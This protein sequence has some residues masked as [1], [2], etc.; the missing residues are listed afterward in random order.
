MAW[1]VDNINLVTLP[2]GGH[3][4]G[5]NCNTTLF[6]LLHPV[7]SSTAGIA[8]DEVDFVLEASAVEN[9]LRC[10]GFTS[11]DMGDNADVAILG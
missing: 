10:S 1:R 5:S 6:F 4:S 8:L 9:S 11:I 7:G 3:S 2:V